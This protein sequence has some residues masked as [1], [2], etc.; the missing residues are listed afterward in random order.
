M[1]RFSYLFALICVLLFACKNT[2]DES[3]DTS[4]YSLFD[5]LLD[6][7]D[8]MKMKQSDFGQEKLKMRLFYEGAINE[9]YPI[10]MR[11]D[12]FQDSLAGSYYYL[13]QKKP[14]SLLGKM[15]AKGT[16]TLYEFDANARST[17]K[18]IGYFSDGEDLNGNWIGANKDFS[19]DLKLIRKEINLKHP[20][21]DKN[22]MVMEIRNF[23]E[24]SEDGFCRVAKQ[25]VKIG[26]L[27]DKTIA[28]RVNIFF[29]PVNEKALKQSANACAMDFRVDGFDEMRFEQESRWGFNSL[30]GSVLSMNDFYYEYTGGAHGNYGSETYNIDLNTGLRLMPEDLFKEGY[31]GA[32]NALIESHI[33]EDLDIPLEHLDFEGVA[34][35][36][37][38][39]LYADRVEVYFNPYEIGPY[40]LGQI[41]LAIPYAELS[42]ILKPAYL[43]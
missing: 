29:Q 30:T 33:E 3:E 32:M 22:G 19:F 9:K 36:Q 42:E 8:A 10:R 25:S 7:P 13:N 2:P 18:F 34:D 41:R 21:F 37:N 43:P 4:L 26:G 27:K 39:E 15:N 23:V 14:L 1:N 12:I 31:Q 5:P 11:L 40:V 6:F 38:Y 24:T 28:E 16:D 17:G 35:D 20:L